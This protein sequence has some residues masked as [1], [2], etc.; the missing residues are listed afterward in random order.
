MGEL[1]IAS[2]ACGD[3]RNKL[4][5]EQSAQNL[6][7]AGDPGAIRSLYSGEKQWRLYFQCCLHE[8][9]PAFFILFYF[10]W[11]RCTPC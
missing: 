5:E 4:I 9:L 3:E 8:Y 6:I 10:V 2:K 1:D 7:D 11:R